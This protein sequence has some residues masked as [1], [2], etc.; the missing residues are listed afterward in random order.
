[1]VRQMERLKASKMADQMV[2]QT[3]YP[4][5]RLMVYR[6]VDPKARLTVNQMVY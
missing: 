4:K 3:V 1:M 2:H 5:A 6:R